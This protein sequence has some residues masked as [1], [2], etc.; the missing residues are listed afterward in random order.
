MRGA[1]EYCDQNVVKS[2]LR[3]QTE[4]ATKQTGLIIGS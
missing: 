3:E 2:T 1:G 4:P